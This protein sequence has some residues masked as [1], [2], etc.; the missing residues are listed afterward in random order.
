MFPCNKVLIKLLGCKAKL[1]LYSSHPGKLAILQTEE[2]PEIAEEELQNSLWI[3]QEERAEIGAERSDMDKDIHP[4]TPK[5]TEP[6]TSQGPRSLLLV[7][8]HLLHGHLWYL[9]A[10]YSHLRTIARGPEER[11]EGCTL[12]SSFPW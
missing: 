7:N 11:N 1:G 12:R 8:R 3:S 10:L 9:W 6:S 5:A 2:E 4:T